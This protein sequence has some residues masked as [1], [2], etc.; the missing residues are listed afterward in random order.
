MLF[1]RADGIIRETIRERF[2]GSTMLII[3]RRLDTLMDVDRMLV[4]DGGQVVVTRAFEL[5]LKLIRTIQ[6]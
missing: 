2:K 6:I 1:Y 4:L 5:F 3:A